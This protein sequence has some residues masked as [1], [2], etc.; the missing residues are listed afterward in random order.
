MIEPVRILGLS[1]STRAKSHNR[2]LVEIA[3]SAAARA[4]AEVQLISLRDFHLPLY[5][6]DLE[7]ESGTP[8][9]AI[10]LKA[11]F[12]QCDGFLVASPEY[13]GLAHRGAEERDRLAFRVRPSRAKPPSHC[14]PSRERSPHHVGIAGQLGRR[15][16]GLRICGKS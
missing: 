11:L 9:N 14:V 13:N 6:A 15:C 16:V 3:T 5:D 10:A 8:A 1:G 7:A 2:A 4:G 12:V